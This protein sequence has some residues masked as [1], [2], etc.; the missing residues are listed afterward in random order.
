MLKRTVLFT[1]AVMLAA[2]YCRAGDAASAA[3][4]RGQFALTYDDGP[5]FIT[6]D[7]LALLE[8][9]KAKATFFMLG[10]AVRAN[11]AMAKKVREAGHLVANH[12]DTHKNW[13]KI[14]KA[15]DREKVFAAEV[16]RAEEAIVKATGEKPAILR[17]PNGYTAPWVREAAKRMGYRTA[18]WDYGSDWTK[19]PEEKMIAEYL[20]AVRAGNV[21]LMHDGGGKSRQKTL[22]ITAAVLDE[23]QRLGLEPVRLDVLLK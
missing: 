10:E 20:K 15:A 19:L 5:G 14:G 21:L 16:G 17:M 22:R 23:A 13:F 2:G 18:N 8:R 7:L 3:K 9:R 11:P 12:T 4:P 6:G 1:L